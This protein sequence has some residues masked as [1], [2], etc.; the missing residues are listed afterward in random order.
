MNAVNYSYTLEQLK[1][2]CPA[3]FTRLYRENR[4]KL[5]SF[6]LIKSKGNR[7]IAEDVLCDTFHSAIESAPKLKDIKNIQGWLLQIASRR[8]ADHFKKMYRETDVLEN[9]SDISRSF[10][11]ADE[12]PRHEALLLNSAFNCPNEKYKRVITL[13][14]IEN[15]SLNEISGDFNMSRRLSTTFSDGKKVL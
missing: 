3:A 5:F 1:S 2:R 14:Y 8:L 12:L 10:N 13:K 4:N 9:Y 15:K 6:L 7:Q 11:D